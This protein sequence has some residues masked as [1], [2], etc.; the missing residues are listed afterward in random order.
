MSSLHGGPS[1]S[2]CVCFFVPLL[3]SCPIGSS[4]AVVTPRKGL[5]F[6]SGQLGVDESVS[7]SVLLCSTA[8]HVGRSSSFAVGALDQ[9]SAGMDMDFC[10]IPSRP[11][12]T[13]SPSSPFDQ[14]FIPSFVS[15]PL[16]FLQGKLIS[17]DFR[18]QAKQVKH[19]PVCV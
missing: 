13:F 19:D 7:S 5:I 18:E 6:T 9:S 10:I 3:G 4:A 8:F 16:P 15:S 17:D 14:P 11:F 12:F 2:V 1:L